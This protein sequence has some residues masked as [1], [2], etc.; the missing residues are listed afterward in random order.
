MYYHQLKTIPWW[1]SETQTIT[2]LFGLDNSLRWINP[3][4]LFYFSNCWPQQY[5]PNT[6][7]FS[8]PYAHGPSTIMAAFSSSNSSSI[9]FLFLFLFSLS[10]SNQV[11]QN[12][13]TSIFSSNFLLPILFSQYFKS[14]EQQDLVN[15]KNHS[16]V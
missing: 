11:T 1:M 12:P 8:W 15:V 14:K 2:I 16:V 6:C 4:L 5:T 3:N 13:L 7:C 10:T 9:Y